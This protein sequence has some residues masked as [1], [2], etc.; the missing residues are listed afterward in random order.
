MVHAAFTP[1]DSVGA[2]SFEPGR[3]AAAWVPGDFLLTHGSSFYSRL[4][5]FGQGLRIH[6]EDRAYTYW[7][8]AALVAGHDGELI[9]ALGEGVVR[10]HVSRYKECEYTVVHLDATPEDRAQVVAFARWVTD[11]TPRYGW[12]A[13]VSISLTLLTGGKFSFFV[14]GQFICSGLVARALERT[15]AIFNRSPS[16][17]M[18]ADLAKYFQVRVPAPADR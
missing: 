3:E 17:V 14:D 13:I 9:E 2:E 8:H 1:V 15:D 5:R 6:G 12:A 16:H 11:G 7:N 10:T 4:I 18:P